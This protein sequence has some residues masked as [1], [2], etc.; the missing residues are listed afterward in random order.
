MA[1]VAD[2]FI[3]PRQKKDLQ[4]EMDGENSYE[5]DDVES[6]EE[7]DLEE[8][9]DQLKGIR[10]SL[11]FLD[12]CLVVRQPNGRLTLLG[13]SLKPDDP[14]GFVRRP[15]AP[16]LIRYAIRPALHLTL[17]VETDYAKAVRLLETVVVM[18]HGP[19]PE[20]SIAS[21]KEADF[22][23]PAAMGLKH[24]RPA[25]ELYFGRGW[26]ESV[27][28]EEL[29]LA[30]IGST[31]DK[32]L[33]GWPDFKAIAGDKRGLQ[34]WRRGLELMGV[35]KL[36]RI[37][38][39]QVRGRP[40][41]PFKA[42][43]YKLIVNSTTL[44]AG[45]PKAVEPYWHKYLQSIEQKKANYASTY[46]TYDFDYVAWI[47]GLEDERCRSAVVDLIL[48]Y[49]E[50]YQI[51]SATLHRSGSPHDNASRHDV[52]W[53]HAL[54][55]EED[56]KVFRSADGER[57]RPDDLWL[58]EHREKGPETRYA[59]LRNAAP[60]FDKHQSLLT[61][62]GVSRLEDGDA[63]RIVKELHRH[64]LPDTFSPGINRAS[65]S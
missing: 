10:S 31:E 4:S 38:V 35:A 1:P 18:L 49:P 26:M 2:I 20:T 41:A 3:P 48:K 5:S 16:D 58:V 55:S 56:W 23:L 64:S 22:P 63:K 7:D 65:E 52:L 27:E 53:V 17:H 30:A 43:H 42:S 25:S 24:W 19:R 6:E 60:G 29:L 39:R 21:A 50:S 15:R 57:V 62:L 61:Y 46:I 9:S 11:H 13:R 47:E 51:Y 59:H 44:P 37:I 14:K 32:V 33:L 54:R 34:W 36:P 12:D 45:L 28:D 40:S 8:A